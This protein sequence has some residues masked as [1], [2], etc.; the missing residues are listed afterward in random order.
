MNTSE[1]LTRAADL[2]EERGHCKGE[3]R[4][5]D[6]RYCAAGALRVVTGVMDEDGSRT[7]A[8]DREWSAYLAAYGA[9]RNHVGAGVGTWNDVSGRTASEVTSTMRGAAEAARAEQ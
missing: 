9:L 5:D 3:H 4:S 6:G 1:I 2:I 7:R 8:G